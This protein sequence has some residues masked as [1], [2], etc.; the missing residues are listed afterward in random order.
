MDGTATGIRKNYDQDESFLVLNITVPKKWKE[1]FPLAIVLEITIL[2]E[3]NGVL[4][5]DLHHISK[6]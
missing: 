6:E 5:L 1:K 2:K 4:G 3:G